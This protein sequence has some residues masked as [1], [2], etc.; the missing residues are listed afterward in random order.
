MRDY[1]REKA[2]AALASK[3]T[4][5]LEYL[6]N[7]LLKLFETG[8]L[9]PPPPPPP[10]PPAQRI[11]VP[12]DFFPSCICS[13]RNL[14]HLKHSLTTCLPG[15]ADAAMLMTDVDFLAGQC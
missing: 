13:Q 5:E 14:V 1:E 15:L 8:A 2:R 4:K 3:Q 7:I 6:K 9:P 10:I 12:Y 11:C